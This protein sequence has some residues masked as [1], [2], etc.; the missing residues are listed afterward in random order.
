M[1]KKNP[2]KAPEADALI[3]RRVKLKDDLKS[4]V[5][6]DHMW[7][8]REATILSRNESGSYQLEADERVMVFHLDDFE[9]LDA[10]QASKLIDVAP[11]LVT[12]SLTNPRRRKGLDSDSLN[13]LASSVKLHGVMAPILVRPLPGQRMA[14]TAHMVP[15][16]VYEVVAGE[17]RWRAATIAGLPTMPMLVRNLDDAAVME[18]QLV[19]NIERESLDDMEEAEGF[20]RL[21]RDLGYTVEQIAERI[22]KGKGPSYVYK[23]LKL[24]DLAP[25]SR[26]A[27]YEG[28]NGEK[29]I[30]GRSTGLLVARYRPEQQAEVIEFI[31][32]LAEAGEPAPFRK[33]APLVYKR[34]NL[35]LR[36][37]VF[38]IQDETLV[39]GAG[40][41]GTCPKRTLAQ[42]DIFG[43]GESPDSCTDPDCFEFK[44]TAH[45][46]RVREKAQRDGFKVIDGEDA[47]RAM[48]TPHA[49]AITGYVKLSAVA[50]TERGNDGVEREVTFGDAL[51]SMG[52]SAP[53]HRIFIDPHTSQAEPVITVELADKLQPPEADDKPPAKPRKVK[54]AKPAAS[55]E[56]EEIDEIEGALNDW[57][58]ERAVTLR[59]F[60]AIRAGQR[61]ST[62]AVRLAKA[63]FRLA[64]AGAESTLPRVE[65][66]MGWRPELE[67]LDGPDAIAI[68]HTKID[69]M[70]P[71]E[72]G[73]LLAMA[74]AE[75]QINDFDAPDGTHAALAK[76]YG[77]DVLAVRDKVAED[78]ARQDAKPVAEE[79][80]AA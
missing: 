34:F 33:V 53:K 54:A 1:G 3:G 69:A 63:L 17:R 58:T 41:C 40:S 13:S 62:E 14:D 31:A 60:D 78:L 5:G 36:H 80:V 24:C 74:A 11:Y 50:R 72:V 64:E 42:G 38:D 48:P 9:V 57:Q 12:H 67:D 27:M 65:E 19:E 52:K 22:G 61:T 77:V 49:K 47:R 59:I 28:A 6:T 66:Y 44:R 29:P 68:I 39:V 43:D 21:R 51:R 7:A 4:M 45:V 8:G 16:P 37:A 2:A 10:E 32:S 56:E 75:L 76:S 15:R 55:E 25:A 20:E 35:E 46:A 79:G 18:M 23:A 30:L 71:E 73:Q 70:L 26:Q